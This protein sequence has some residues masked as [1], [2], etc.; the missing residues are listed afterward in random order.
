VTF[1]DF[2]DA[3][4]NEKALKSFA[5]IGWP[6]VDLTSRD[7]AHFPNLRFHHDMQVSSIFSISTLFLSSPLSD[8]LDS[9]LGARAIFDTF[10]LDVDVSCIIFALLVSDAISNADI[11]LSTLL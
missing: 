9:F 3:M 1:F 7:L 11:S 2:S 10:S 4:S 8:N 5:L 6:S